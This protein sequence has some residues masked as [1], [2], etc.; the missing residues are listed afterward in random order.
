MGSKYTS[1]YFSRE[2]K[3]LLRERGIS[4]STAIR[5]HNLGWKKE[6]ILNKPTNRKSNNKDWG[7]DLYALYKGDEFITTGTAFDI[8]K[9]RGVKVDE[10]KKYTYPSWQKRNKGNALILEYIGRDDEEEII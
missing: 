7:N 2:E 3:K 8:A 9:V 1:K 10:I 5:R 6:D 4:L